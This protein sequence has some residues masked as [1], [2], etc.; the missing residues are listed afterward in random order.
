MAAADAGEPD[1][2]ELVAAVRSG[3]LEAYGLLYRRHAGAARTQA[4]QLVRSRPDEEDLVAEAFA[5]VLDAIRAGG[6]PDQAFRAYLLTTVRNTLR[7][8][9][10]RDR[11]L[12]WTD[13]PG[14][15]AA[16]LPWEDPAV[17]ALEATLAARA[18]HRLPE[19]WREVIWRTEVE[20]APRPEV[21]SSLG[22]S[23]SGVAALAYRARERLRQAYLQ[24]HIGAGAGAGTAGPGAAGAGAAG[25]G[26]AGAGAARAGAGGA[27]AGGA[28]AQ[29]RAAV[30]RLGAWTR[31]RLSGRQRAGVEAHLTRCPDCR[32]LARELADVNGGLDR[33]PAGRREPRDAA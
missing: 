11:P 5:K 24:E 9:L 29:H 17:A 26:A 6:G 31:G 32:A 33:E 20:P 14:R 1:D 3:D 28:G 18:F 2:A 23:P 7:D 15:Y 8:R 21:A 10:R 30:D 16:G 12:Q 19:R 27:G 13:D 4:K 25:V 22:L